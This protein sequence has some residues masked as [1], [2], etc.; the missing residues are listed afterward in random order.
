MLDVGITDG[1]WTEVKKGDMTPG[2]ELV[3]EQREDKKK[4]KFGLF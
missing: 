1:V 2:T 4:K 3:V